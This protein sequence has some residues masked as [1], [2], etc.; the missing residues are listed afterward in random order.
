MA[1]L[2]SGGTATLL[3]LGLWVRFVEAVGGGR[4]ARVVAV[5]CET[6]FELLDAQAEDPD[7]VL[8]GGNLRDDRVG[9]LIVES[10]DL[11][12][13]AHIGQYERCDSKIA[14]QPRRFSGVS[15]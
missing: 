5:L 1:F 4:F 7:G 3:A 8:E 11:F 2:A 15:G 10:V 12:A 6:V 13:C 9:S 14:D